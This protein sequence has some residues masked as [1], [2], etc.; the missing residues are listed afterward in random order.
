MPTFG[1]YVGKVTV[2]DWFNDTAAAVLNWTIGMVTMGI[3]IQVIGWTSLFENTVGEI[4]NFGTE[5]MSQTNVGA[6]STGTGGTSSTGTG[7]TTTN[8]GTST[9]NGTSSTNTGTSSGGSL[10]NVLKGDHKVTVEDVIFNRVPLLDANFFDFANAGGK[11]LSQNSLIYKVR[12][13]I[14]GWYSTLR[15]IA[16][17]GMLAMLIYIAIRMALSN[18]AEDKA[19]YKSKFVD[20]LIGF[21]IVLTIHYF[22][23]AIITINDQFVKILDFSA[24]SSTTSTTQSGTTGDGDEMTANE[25][26]GA[27]MQG[28]STVGYT[29]KNAV[30]PDDNSQSIYETV[31]IQAYDVQASTGWTATIIYMVLVFFLVRFVVFYTVRLFTLAILTI[32][33]PLMGVLYA[34]NKRVYALKN[35]GLEYGHNVLIQLVHAIIY[36]AF[37]SIALQLTKTS[38]FVGAIIA[39]VFLGFMLSAEELVKKI[40]N[41][42]SKSLPSL[43]NSSLMATAAVVGARKL[44]PKSIGLA[45]TSITGTGS[46]INYVRNRLRGTPPNEE[47]GAQSGIHGMPNLGGSDGGGSRSVDSGDGNSNDSSPDNNGEN[48]SGIVIPPEYDERGN[49]SYLTA[50]DIE[51]QIKDKEKEKSAARREFIW[52]SAGNAVGGILGTA[53]LM[54][55]IPVIIVSPTKGLGMA[56]TSIYSMYRGFKPSR[57]R[58]K[59]PK[60][61]GESKRYT[62]GKLLFGWASGGATLAAGSLYRNAEG[63]KAHYNIP[64]EDLKQ[65]EKARELEDQLIRAMAKFQPTAQ[66]QVNEV[67]KQ[68][69][70]RDLAQALDM[71]FETVTKQEVNQ[72][73]TAY[74]LKNKVLNVEVKDIEKIAEQVND[75]L[76][77]EDKNLIVTDQFTKNLKDE[78]REKVKAVGNYATEED[79]KK[80]E[81]SGE[82]SRKAPRTKDK[83]HETT[84]DGDT[85]RKEHERKDVDKDEHEK[86]ES[87]DT[88]EEALKKA[89]EEEIHTKEKESQADA[90]SLKDTRKVIT[91]EELD[92]KVE[93]AVKGMSHKEII[94]LMTEALQKEGSIYREVPEKYEPVMKIVKDLDEVNKNYVERTGEPIYPS[95]KNLVKYI[96]NQF[97][98]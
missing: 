46:G 14:A 68:T 97:N 81:Q 24:N 12:Q 66:N 57:H 87:V 94:E 44:V 65:L 61:S 62:S 42:G 88:L 17:M 73:V 53:A 77:E 31:R 2:L 90:E 33:S 19:N 36:S 45:K 74:I 3:K 20:W 72:A 6:T 5:D 55:S 7:S 16:I 67:I 37:I 25:Q 54:A 59:R 22:M 34:M 69:N 43:A 83:N 60:V 86:S 91:E 63:R 58:L 96:Q 39:V 21:I 23:L 70:N 8:T 26:F 41:F 75:L 79:L 50:S 82:T 80:K 18:V 64:L 29:Q 15:T 84:T 28:L 92:Q 85:L 49:P 35:W 30:Q 1:E 4:L 11:Q 48:Q 27:M 89:K 78:I 38:T 47:G 40:F 76:K 9:N 10:F 13:G 56:G 71:T 93:E 52:K 95:I 98:K 32:I 51:Q